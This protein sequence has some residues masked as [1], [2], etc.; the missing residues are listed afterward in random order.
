M[1]K[2]GKI[3]NLQSGGTCKSSGQ[4]RLG[5]RGPVSYFRIGEA[6]VEAEASISVVP[7]RGPAET[8]VDQ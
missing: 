8:E 1:S 7:V 6:D 2:N 4:G 3:H 5:I